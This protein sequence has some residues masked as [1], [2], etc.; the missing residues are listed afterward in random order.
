MGAKAPSIPRMW[1]IKAMRPSIR[2]FPGVY[3]FKNFKIKLILDK[4]FSPPPLRGTMRVHASPSRGSPDGTHSVSREIWIAADV[5]TVRHA[6]LLG[7][8]LTRANPRSEESPNH[9]QC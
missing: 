2:L 3:L 5:S 8:T 9:P 7:D 1:G 6:L 4:D